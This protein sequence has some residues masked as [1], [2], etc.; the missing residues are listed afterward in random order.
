MGNSSK[1]KI[2]YYGN[3]ILRQRCNEVTEITDEI[4]DLAHEMIK[5][6][7]KYNGMGFAAPQG[8]YPLRMFVI[9]NHSVD[10]EGYVHLTTPQVFINPKILSTS[11]EHESM[12][13]GC[14]SI[15]GIREHVL[16]P[17]KITVQATDLNGKTFVETREGLD[18]RVV[19]HENDHI[20][21]VLYI[22]RIDKSLRK[23]IDPILKKIKKKYSE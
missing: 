13:E 11:E 10:D 1:L 21:G 8:G 17:Y 23:K 20:N 18:A 14:L 7:D 6:M 4:R 15:P 12:T 19:L 16:R 5:A 22:D 2:C 3:P 9:Y